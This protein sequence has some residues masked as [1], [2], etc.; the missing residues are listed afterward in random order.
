MA[1][2]LVKG[3]KKLFGVCSGLANYLDI[4][5]TV[6]RIIFVLAFFGFGVG[7][8]IYIVMALIMPDK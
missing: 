8:L 2:K 6:M 5:P 3:E 4:D 7:L 1:K